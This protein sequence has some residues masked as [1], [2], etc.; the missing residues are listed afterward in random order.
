MKSSLSLARQPQRRQH[1]SQY[2]L[3]LRTTFARPSL[4]LHQPAVSMLPLLRWPSNQEGQPNMPLSQP[5]VLPYI[6][7]IGLFC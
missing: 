6:G 5:L 1:V 2:T 7:E 4:R 3:D